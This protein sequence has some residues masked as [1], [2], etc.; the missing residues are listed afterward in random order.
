MLGSCA[1]HARRNSYVAAAEGRDVPDRLVGGTG[2]GGDT[3][4]VA[5]CVEAARADIIDGLIAERLRKPWLPESD[6]LLDKLGSLM[7][8][9]LLP[10]L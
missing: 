1:G 8:P 5:G 7:W 10:R 2:G 4:T 9:S 3:T 6:S